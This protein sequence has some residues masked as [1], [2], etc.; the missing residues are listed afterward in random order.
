VG[1]LPAARMAARRSVDSYNS[2]R[3]AID[4]VAIRAA[5]LV[6]IAFLNYKWMW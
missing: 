2:N 5:H 1:G 6:R 4:T 3:N